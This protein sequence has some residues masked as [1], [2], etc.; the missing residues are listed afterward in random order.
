MF[1]ILLKAELPI[2]VVSGI[3]SQKIAA[4]IWSRIFDEAVP[5]TAQQNVRIGML[6]PAAVVE[7]TMYKLVRMG[8]DRGLRV[9]AARSEGTWIGRTGEGE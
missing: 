3:V 5:D 4:K 7:G 2:L 1:T 8:V 9:A 6:I